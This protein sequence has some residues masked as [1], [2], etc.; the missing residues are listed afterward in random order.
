MTW[1]WGKATLGV[2]ACSAVRACIIHDVHTRVHCVQRCAC[3]LHCMQAAL[4]G[5]KAHKVEAV[6]RIWMLALASRGVLFLGYH[7]S[8]NNLQ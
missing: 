7:C 6:P 3:R 4:R 2:V 1:Q 5:A 8:Y